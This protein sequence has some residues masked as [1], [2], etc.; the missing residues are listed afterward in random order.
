MKS[1]TNLGLHLVGN[2]AEDLGMTFSQYRQTQCGPGEDSNMQRIDRIVGKALTDIKKKAGVDGVYPNLTAGNTEHFIASTSSDTTESI[3]YTIRPTGGELSMDKIGNRAKE[4]IVGGTVVWNQI[5]NMEDLPSED[6]GGIQKQYNGDGSVTMTGIA[7]VSGGIGAAVSNYISNEYFH[8]HH[9]YYLTHGVGSDGSSTTFW[10]R[11]VNGRQYDFYSKDGAITEI[12]N[13]G[14]VVMGVHVAKDYDVSEGLT[15]WP[16]MIDLTTM[17]GP[18]IANALLAMETATPGSGVEWFLRRLHQGYH[19]YTAP[20]FKHV[21]VSAKNAVGFNAL[22]PET[23]TANVVGGQQYQIVGTYTGVSMDGEVIVP[24]ENG[25]FTPQKDGEIG[26]TGAGNDTCVHLV[27]T[28]S[29]DDEYADYESHTYP[30]DE[31]LELRGMPH[32]ASDGTILYDGDQYSSDGTVTRKYGL[33]DYVSG[34][35]SDATVLTDGTA[36][37]YLLESTETEAADPFETFMWVDKWGTEMFV[38]VSDFGFDMPV[39]HITSYPTDL[40]DAVLKTPVSPDEN[41]VY[42]LQRAGGVNTYVPYHDV[43]CTFTDDGDGNIVMSI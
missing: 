4:T 16:E 23:W 27:R 25:Y 12:P 39:G 13:N 41:G 30:L 5:L 32:L 11:M 36:T 24:G 1:S 33:R 35:E 18:T 3:P 42:V 14:S 6:Y 29:R 10:M 9:V 40:T 7:T 17:F 15:F 21:C 43:A 2:T 22:D 8:R 31:A 28:G 37:L 20:T 19:P 38:P 26:V 34:D